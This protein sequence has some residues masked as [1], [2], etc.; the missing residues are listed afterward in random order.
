MNEGERW[1]FF[2][3]QDLRMAELALTDELYNQVCFH[4]QQCAEKALKAWLVH[5]GK[6][7]PRTH[8]LSDLLSLLDP[9]PV[10]EIAL[11]IQLLDRFYIP[12]RYPDALPGSL[13]EGLPDVQDAEQSLRLAG[14][15]LERIEKAIQAK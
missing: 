3:R 9:N 1:L 5:Q 13:V 4:A 8:S 6:T 14:Q 12:T 7:P 2:A 15:T 11:E 10:A